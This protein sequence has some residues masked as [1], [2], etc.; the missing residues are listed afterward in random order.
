VL[1]TKLN[2]VPVPEKGILLTSKLADLLGVK[3]AQVITVEVLEGKRPVQQLVVSGLAD[4]MLGLSAYMQRD[5]LNQLM[6]EGS[7]ISGSFLQVDGKRESELYTLLKRTPGIGAVAIRQAALD[8]FNETIN[9]LALSL[10]TLIIF[11]SII[12]IGMIY[13]GARIALSERANELAS[14][15][16]LGFTRLEISVLLLGEQAALTLMAVPF[17]YL[18]GYAACAL[19]ARKSAN[20]AVPPAAVDQSDHVCLVIHHCCFIRFFLSSA[21]AEKVGPLGSGRGPEIE[22][23]AVS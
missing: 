14:L 18:L 16:V 17:G 13:N 22:R 11:A 1:D 3:P 6:Q 2:D 20:G 15:R 5:A 10:T 19:L 8:S 9:R 7:T 12:A 21:G 23:V 4:E